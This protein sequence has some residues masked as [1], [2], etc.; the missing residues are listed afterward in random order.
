MER[1]DDRFPKRKNPRLKQYDYA[2]ANFYFV[3]ICTN[4]KKCIFGSPDNLNSFG[5]FAKEGL[6]LIKKHFTTVEIDQ[7]VVMPNHI[8]AIIILSANSV[9]LTTVVGSYKSYVTKK[10]HQLDPKM[11]VWQVSF[12]DHVIRNQQAYETI[13]NYIEYNPMKWEEDCFYSNP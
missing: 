3:T 4:E 5:K 2:T 12:H 11:K 7:F 1:P 9:K 10:I 6:Q 13:W 8:H